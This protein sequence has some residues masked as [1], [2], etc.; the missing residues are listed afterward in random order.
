MDITGGSINNGIWVV[1]T[2]A[3]SRSVDFNGN[4]DAAMGTIVPVYNGAGTLGLYALSNTSTVTIGTSVITFENVG[5]DGVTLQGLLASSTDVANGDALVAVKKTFTG[6]VATTQH[7]VNERTVN[8][9]DF[10]SAADQA[11]AIART[12]PP[13]V[14]SALAA[15]VAELAGGGVLEIPAGKFYI[16]AAQALTSGITIQ[17]AS[18]VD[19]YYGIPKTG[20]E[21]PTFLYQATAATPIFTVGEGVCDVAWKNISLSAV[22]IPAA[23]VGDGGPTLPTAGKYGIRF[24]GDALN[25]SYRF[26]FEQV[27]FYNF[28]RAISVSDVAAT[29]GDWQCDNVI[30]SSCVFFNNTYG[31]YFNTINADVWKFQHC[32]FLIADNGAGIYINFAGYIEMDNC[33]GGPAESIGNLPAT[34]NAY[35]YVA[36][37]YDNIK[38]ISCQSENI[39]YFLRV[40]TS[41]GY[42]NNYELITLDGCA[43]ESPCL[44]ERQAKIISLASRYTETVTCSGNDIEVHS[45]GDSWL[46]TTKKFDMTGLRPRLFV[47]AGSTQNSGSVTN[48][49]TATPTT[50]TSL[51]ASAGVYQFYVYW[52]NSGSTRVAIATLVCD[53]TTL[54]RADGV[55]GADMTITVSARNVQA[56][57]SSGVNQTVYW[58]YLRIA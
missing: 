20:N 51:P 5:E 31:V 29:A 11:A 50:M 22:S 38:L 37:R 35:V 21:A 27:T 26:V 18:N 7:Q 3:W 15:A 57:Q 55:N 4:Y 14:T 25:S 46:P 19:P 17:G 39:D 43:V 48:V 49:V 6:A 9:F 36:Y 16:T 12:S 44:I 41:T 34:G 53:G 30:V 58:K 42:E 56:T 52:P 40:D 54:I 45:Y 28:E 32:R 23:K 8:L 24:L 47:D 13:N 2:A 33:D 10:M 1:S